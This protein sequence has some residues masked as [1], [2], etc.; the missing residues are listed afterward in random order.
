MYT[1]HLHTSAVVT[2]YN[3]N[4]VWGMSMSVGVGV[5]AYFSLECDKV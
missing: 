3:D 1:I 2:Y 4:H 5:L